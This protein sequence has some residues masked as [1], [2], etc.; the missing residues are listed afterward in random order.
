ME[1]G[2]TV[3]S[4]KKRTKKPKEIVDKNYTQH[5]YKPYDTLSQ[6][7]KHGS[8]IIV[9]KRPDMTCFKETT[10]EFRKALERARLEK[11]LTRKKL[12]EM[13]NEKISIIDGCETGKIYPS[14]NV[15]MKLNSVLGVTLPKLNKVKIAESLG[16][17]E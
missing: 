3:V 5:H 8:N 15:I 6:L 16:V 11:N 7:N 4:T 1:D 12:A 14:N 10:F 2:W 13:I 17:I 9:K